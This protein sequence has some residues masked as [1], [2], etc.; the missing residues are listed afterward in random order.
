MTVPSGRATRSAPAY[1]RVAI[2]CARSATISLPRFCFRNLRGRRRCR[3][4]R[5]SVCASLL[6][7]IGRGKIVIY[8]QRDTKAVSLPRKRLY[9]R[10]AEETGIHGR[11][12]HPSPGIDR[13]LVLRCRQTDPRSFTTT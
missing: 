6:A 12:L 3:C 7:V 11:E 13:L 9:A 1:S 4:S 2:F 10:V 5:W 8:S